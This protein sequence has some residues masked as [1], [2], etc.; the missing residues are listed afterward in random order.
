MFPHKNVEYDKKFPGHQAKEIEVEVTIRVKIKMVH[1]VFLSDAEY[2]TTHSRNAFAKSRRILEEHKRN[3]EMQCYARYP[4]KH[5]FVSKG[6][7][8]KKQKAHKVSKRRFK[9]RGL[10]KQGW[11]A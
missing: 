1:I 10:L 7:L 11:D 4:Q 6:A 8:R 3:R 9:W 2:Q 5:K